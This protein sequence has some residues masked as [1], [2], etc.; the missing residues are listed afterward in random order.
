MGKTAL[1]TNIAFNDTKTT[2]E[3]ERNP[4]LHFFHWKCPQNSYQQEYY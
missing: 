1:T 4:L 3:V 2:R